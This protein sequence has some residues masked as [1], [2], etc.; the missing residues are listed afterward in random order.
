MADGTNERTD[1]SIGGNELYALSALESAESHLAASAK[2]SGKGDEC[3]T[4]FA[5]S[6]SAF[7]DWGEKASLIRPIEDFDFFQRNPDGHGDEHQA[8]F[9]EFSGR[10]Y[11]STYPNRFGLAWG[12][13]GSATAGEYLTR[14]VLQNRYFADDIQLLSLVR[15]DEKLRV[16]TTQPHVPGEAALAAE[17]QGWFYAQGY[18]RLEIDNCVA[19]YRDLDNLLVADAHE[20]NV[21]CTPDGTLFAIDLNLIKPRGETLETLLSLLPFTHPSISK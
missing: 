3:R 4:P 15:C 20:G 1:F 19:W 8:W 6:F 2:A 11:K 18:K 7:L 17:I 12:R 5:A 21:I 13:N 14:L 9:D 10:W 16:L